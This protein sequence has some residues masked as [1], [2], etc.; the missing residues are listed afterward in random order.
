MIP[1]LRV[2]VYLLWTTD[3][4]FTC[5]PWQL[6][7]DNS[8]LPRQNLT[9]RCRC[10][11]LSIVDIIIWSGG[12]LDLWTFISFCRCPKLQNRPQHIQIKSSYHYLMI[13]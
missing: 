5:R 7:S 10:V 4:V 12:D 2:L 11:W 9:T 6:F 13:Y 1:H 3:A 8:E